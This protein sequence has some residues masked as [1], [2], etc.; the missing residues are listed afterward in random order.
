MKVEMGDRKKRNNCHAMA[1]RADQKQL[2]GNLARFLRIKNESSR[3][4]GL[5]A[6]EFFRLQDQSYSK[7]GDYQWDKLNMTK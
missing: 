3:L 5:S 1:A 2:L 7:K 6:R 4:K